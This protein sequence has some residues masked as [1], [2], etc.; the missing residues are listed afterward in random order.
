MLATTSTSSSGTTGLGT[1]LWKPARSDC[2]RSCTREWAVRA[3]A[4]M[5]P[6]LSGGSARIFRSNP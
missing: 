5:R 1:W 3:M 6:P 4:G 2:K